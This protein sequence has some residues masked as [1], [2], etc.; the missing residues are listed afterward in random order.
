MALSNPAAA[1]ALR[2]KRAERAGAALADE[3][4]SA[5]EEVFEDARDGESDDDEAEQQLQTIQQKVF[6]PEKAPSPVPEPSPSP[7]Q[8]VPEELRQKRLQ[9]HC[10]TLCRKQ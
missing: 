5:S 8:D 1:D 3:L 7:V 6:S 2:S 10:H 4:A 9:Y